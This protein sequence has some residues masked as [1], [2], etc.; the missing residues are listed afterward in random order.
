MPVHM[1]LKIDGIEG[2]SQK[3][4][5]AKE[6]ELLSW[7]WAGHNTGSFAHGSGGGTGQYGS[8]DVSF[9]KY[10]DKA[11]PK[12]F[13]ACSKGTHIANALL[14]VGK[15]GGD[16]KPYTF[17][18]LK[19]EHCLISSHQTGGNSGSTDM[20]TESLTFNFTKITYEY[21]QQDPKQGSVTSTGPVSY[22]LAQAK[23]A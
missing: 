4:G 15:S 2:E 1:F 14:S 21:F 11:S 17:L 13:Q 18:T 22:D 3:E 5:H 19:F 9:T 10:I 12:L 16:T 23:A 7:N 6:M 20:Y 8:S